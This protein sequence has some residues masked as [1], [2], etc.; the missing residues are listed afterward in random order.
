VGSRRE[1]YVGGYLLNFSRTKMKAHY[2]K[3]AK[4]ESVDKPDCEFQS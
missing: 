1:E 3:R 2:R 4:G